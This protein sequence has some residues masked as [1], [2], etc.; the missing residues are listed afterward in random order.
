MIRVLIV[1]DHEMVRLG[2][3]SFLKIQNDIEVVAEAENGLQAYDQTL[4]FRPDIILMDLVMDV[5]DGI[6]ASQKIIQVWPEARIIIL[7]SFLDDEKVYPALEAGA[8][9]Y[10]LKTSSAEEIV[11]AI[12]MTASGESFM[13]EEVTQKILHQ[14][15]QQKQGALHDELTKREIEVLQLIAKGYTNQAIADTLFISFKTVKSHVSYILA[16]LQV[17]DRTQATIYAFQHDLVH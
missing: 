6:E 2:I 11:Q 16:K 9:S 3:S 12:R 15:D 17:Y 13:Q 7:T 14:E 4:K 10:I 5:M 1:D 8:K